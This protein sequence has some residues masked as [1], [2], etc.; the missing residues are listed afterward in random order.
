MT[1]LGAGEG[2]E[3]GAGEG[4]GDAAAGNS[5]RD[6]AG[7]EVNKPWGKCDEKWPSK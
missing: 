5:P 4:Q 3:A 7:S 1:S 6:G 2:R